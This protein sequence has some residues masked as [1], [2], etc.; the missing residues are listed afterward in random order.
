MAEQIEYSKDTWHILEKEFQPNALAKFESIFSL[1]NGYLGTRAALEESYAG[2]T[3]DT[4]ING[5]FDKFDNTEVSELPNLPDVFKIDLQV[6]GQQLDLNKGQVS[7]YCLSFDTKAGVLDRKFDWKIYNDSIHFES[8]RFVSFS[9]K[10]LAGSCI[11]IKNTGTKI[12]KLQLI[13]GIDGAV[14]NSGSQHLADG[15]K[16][17]FD[18]KILSYFTNTNQSKVK[19]AVALGQQL[20][21]DF[22]VITGRAV[23]PRR[24]LEQEFNVELLP[25][26][27]VVL[28]KLATYF[29]SRDIDITYKDQKSLVQKSIHQASHAISEGFGAEKESS[30][31]SWNNE[32]WQ[33]TPIKIKTNNYLD[34]VALHFARYHLHAMTSRDDPR[35]NIAAKGLSGEGYKGHTFWDTEMFI[36]PYFIYTY[37]KI[38]KNLV[39][40]R[41]L[42]LGGARRK[43]ADNDFRGAEYPWESAWIKDGENTPV[44]GDADIV[45][46]EPTKIWTGFIEQHIT[47]DVAYGVYQYLAITGDKE[48]GKK[49][50]Y[51]IILDTARFWAS[52]VTFNGKKDR[53]EIDNVIGPNEYKEHVNNNAFTNYMAYWNMCYALK[54]IHNLSCNDSVTYDRLDK[55]LDLSELSESINKVLPKFY[56]PKPNNNNVIPENDTYFSKKIIDLSKYLESDDV[57][58][59]FKKYNLSQINEMQITKQSD[60]ILLLYVLK[61]Q[62]DKKVKISNWNYY[63]PKTT[64]DSSLSMTTHMIVA[65]EL[66]KRK[67]AIKYYDRSKMIDLG[68][69]MHSSDEGI[70]AASLGGVWEMTIQGFGG[71]SASSDELIVNPH[72]PDQW[73]ALDFYI[74]YQGQRI[75]VIEEK[76]KVSFAKATGKDVHL[77]VNG[78]SYVLKDDLK[79]NL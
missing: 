23:M 5:T 6:N 71:V 66:G 56:L 27:T 48:F 4:F 63:V 55:S 25:G 53:Y 7:N 19:I 29:T 76:D 31:E 67:E 12:A 21:K 13:S 1:G 3:R 16:R 74:N 50:G 32:V 38:A 15:E 68:Q 70:H 49:Y 2:E 24:K 75:H 43:A 62:F 65:E 33:K 60:V 17:I 22:R 44:W 35:V 57:S 40:Y 47:A 78:K 41:Y 69:N 20:V 34:I 30:L 52:R 42:S 73:E 46:G 36:L 26:E 58:A 64:H 37:P 11:N 9:N 72:L 10:H 45:T 14:S 77:S 61:D 28:T 59:L 51:E 79:I 8:S 54:L 18:K 39:L